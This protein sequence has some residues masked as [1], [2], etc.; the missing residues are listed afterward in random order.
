M[1]TVVRTESGVLEGE[2]RRDHIAFRGIPYAAAPTGLRRFLPPAPPLPWT[3]VREARTFGSSAIQGESFAP[4]TQ[5][6]GPTSE[7]CLYLNVYTPSIDGR[8]RPVLVFIHG[9]AFVVGSSSAPIYDGGRLAA[10]GDQVVVTFNY[11]LGALGYLC[12]G[13]FGE[14]WGASPNTGALDQVAALGWVKANID[15][16]GGDPDRVTIFGESAGAASAL[17]LIATPS[18]EGLFHRVIAESA[19]NSLTLAEPAIAMRFAE[20]LLSHLGITFRDSE[21]LRDVSV[22]RLREAQLKVRGR[23]SERWG[24]VAFGFFPVIDAGTVPTQPR[25]A[26]IEG[27]GARVPLVIGTNR[28]EWNLMEL[29]T[30]SDGEPIPDVVA[31]LAAQGFP[32]PPEAIPRFFEIYRASRKEKKLPHHDRALRRALLGDCRFRIPSIRFAEAHAARGL[33]TYAYLFTY[34]S[35]ALRGVLGACHAL[36]LPFVFG[37]LDAPLQDRFAGTGEDVRALSASMMQSWAAFAHTGNP[38]GDGPERAWPCFD[39]KDRLT[40]IFDRTSRVE[41]APLDAER[42]AWDGVTP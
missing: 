22:E 42:R 19:S 13:E 40:R 23:R 29:P 21:K 12:L 16:F 35:P 2:Q 5:A 32:A 11:R 7:D 14:R 25:D 27:R 17:N 26:F 10:F 3:G 8:R 31:E 37:T 20:E 6:E 9:G 4:G 39:S 1:P 15:R 28:D 34:C 18:A 38:A 36:E 41:A 33:P 30:P 24:S